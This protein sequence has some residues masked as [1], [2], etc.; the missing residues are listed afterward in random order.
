[1]QN[2]L[3]SAVQRIKELAGLTDQQAL[4]LMPH[5]D[6]SPD[7]FPGALITFDSNEKSWAQQEYEREMKQYGDRPTR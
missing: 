1:M 3:S 6:D 7:G 4:T 5:G 2:P